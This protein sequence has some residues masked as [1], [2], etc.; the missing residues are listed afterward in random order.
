MYTVSIMSIRAFRFQLRPKPGTAHA[1]RRFAGACRWVWN[2][3][4]GEQQRLRAAGEKFSGY[5]V[6]CR[7]LTV[8]RNDPDTAWLA[9]TPVQAQQQTLKRL[10]ASYRRFFEGQ[11]GYPRFRGRGQDAGLRFPKASDCKLDTDN[12]RLKPP[13][14]GWVRMRQ[15]QSVEGEVRNWTLTQE[16]GR[17]FVSIQ[18]EQA[19]VIPAAGL[20]PT[21]GIDFGVTL[22]AATTDGEC[23]APLNALKRQQKY[24]KRVQRSVSR[25]VKGSKNRRKAIDR[26]GRVHARIVAQR[27]DWLHKLTTRWANEHPV[28]AIEDLKVAAMSASAQGTATAPGKK[29]RQKAG[30][31]RSILDQAWGEARRQLEYKTAAR[32]GAVVPVDPAYTSQRC[33]A[34]GHTARENRPTQARFACE[35]CGH[36]ENADLNAAKNIL[37]AG[38][39]VWVARPEAC[40][41]EVRR[42]RPVRGR[43]AAARKQEPA[44]GSAAQAVA[45][46]GIPVL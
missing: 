5:A 25:K 41:A 6:M 33:S 20:V 27:S 36:S 22:F 31:N 24:L 3:A 45:P 37:A 38:H 29:L 17:W 7:W 44:E 9:E 43:R 2:R 46:A 32:G 19:D 16:R 42:A 28:I 21:L 13:K 30:L 14:L 18:V 1:L 26:L 8:W 40:G 23:V 10:E 35:A 34:C 12:Q 4:I 39:A 15:S 11:G